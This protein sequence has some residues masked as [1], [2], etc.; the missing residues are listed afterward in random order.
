MNVL[1][2]NLNEYRS[3]FCQKFPCNYQ[4]ITEIG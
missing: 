2:A 3:R 1:I 4:A